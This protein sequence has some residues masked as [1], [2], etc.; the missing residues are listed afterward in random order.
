M[1]IIVT[2]VDLLFLWN[3]SEGKRKM[4]EYAFVRHAVCDLTFWPHVMGPRLRE[5]CEIVCENE[6]S[7]ESYDFFLDNE[8]LRKKWRASL[9][10]GYSGTFPMP[11]YCTFIGRHWRN[12][13]VTKNI[14]IF[15]IHHQVLLSSSFTRLTYEWSSGKLTDWGGACRSHTHY[16]HHHCYST[17]VVDLRARRKDPFNHC[18]GSSQSMY[19]L[20]VVSVKHGKTSLQ[21]A[22]SAP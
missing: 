11:R 4:S 22:S 2:T 18:V 1:H 14:I 15:L 16:R 5:S 17:S 20:P 3:E 10:K 8:K 13:S 19:N 9:G 21:C 12:K 6:E 7:C